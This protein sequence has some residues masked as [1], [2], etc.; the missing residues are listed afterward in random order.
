MERK[1]NW[2]RRKGKKAPFLFNIIG[3]LRAAPTLEAASKDHGF[4]PGSDSLQG[5]CI[6]SPRVAPKAKN[7]VNAA[8]VVTSSLLTDN[9]T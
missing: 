5:L 2:E 3:T 1:K 8:I 9:L 7:A 4:Q 6:A